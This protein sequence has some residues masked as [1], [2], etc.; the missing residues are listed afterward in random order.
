M[1]KNFKSYNF[2]VNTSGLSCWMITHRLKI[3]WQAVWWWVVCVWTYQIIQS[4]SCCSSNLS[5]QFHPLTK[6]SMFL[7]PNRLWL[8]ACTIEVAKWRASSE[9]LATC[10]AWNVA[11]NWWPNATIWSW[12]NT[13]TKLANRSKTC[14][15]PCMK[16]WSNS[17]ANKVRMTRT[18]TATRVCASTLWPVCWR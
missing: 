1:K 15:M 7:S 10:C 17:W 4:F 14:A 16:S 12:L 18:K 11:N 9:S 8:I 2:G 6:P 13:S 5:I 3:D